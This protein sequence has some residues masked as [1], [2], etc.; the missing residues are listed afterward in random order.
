MEQQGD[1]VFEEKGRVVML[2]MIYLFIY[3]KE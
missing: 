2:R 1:V 3:F